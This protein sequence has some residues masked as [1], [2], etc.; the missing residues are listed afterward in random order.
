[1]FNQHERLSHWLQQSANFVMFSSITEVLDNKKSPER[2]FFSV[3]EEEKK[4]INPNHCLWCFQVKKKRFEVLLSLS[5]ISFAM[6][7]ARENIRL[8]YFKDMKC[9]KMSP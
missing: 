9:I 7:T 3:K 1:M 4:K 2:I 5:L 8:Y 6:E